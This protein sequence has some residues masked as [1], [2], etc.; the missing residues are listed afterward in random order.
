MDPIGLAVYAL[1]VAGTA[2]YWPHC[3]QPALARGQGSALARRVVFAVT[4]LTIAAYATA[5]VS[6]IAQVRVPGMWWITTIVGAIWIVVV[7]L[8]YFQDYRFLLRVTGSDRK[9][10]S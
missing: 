7:A 5:I 9:P 10:S 8:G 2:W 6:T 1:I 3:A 4:V